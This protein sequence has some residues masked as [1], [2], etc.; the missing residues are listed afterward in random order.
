LLRRV[1]GVPVL[2]RIVPVGSVLPITHRRLLIAVAEL[3]SSVFC[4][5]L[6]DMVVPS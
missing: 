6:V 5:V 2:R 3:A 1:V 4:V